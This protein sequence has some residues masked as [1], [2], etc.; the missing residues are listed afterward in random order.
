[1]LLSVKDD[2]PALVTENFKVAISPL[3]LKAVAGATETAAMWN[4]PIA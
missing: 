3:P 2:C 1:M 4:S